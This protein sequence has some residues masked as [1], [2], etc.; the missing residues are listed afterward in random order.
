MGSNFPISKSGTAFGSFIVSTTLEKPDA[1][2][3]K[4]IRS[5][6]MRGKNRRRPTR[7]NA[8]GNKPSPEKDMGMPLGPSSRSDFSQDSELVIMPMQKVMSDSF[9]LGFGNALKP[10]M[11]EL[12]YRAFTI[13]KPATYTVQTLVEGGPHDELFCLGG[14]TQSPAMM[15]TVVFIAQAYHE[16]SCGAPLGRITQFHLSKTLNYLQHSL[17][18]SIDATSNAT[19]AIVTS[20]AMAAILLGELETAT[21]HMDG[22]ARMVELRGGFENLGNGRII[23]HKSRSIDLL[24]AISLGSK[25][26]FGEN[27]NWAQLATRDISAADFPE[28]SGVCPPPPSTLLGVWAILQEFSIAANRAIA[29]GTKIPASLFVKIST[30]VTYQL[31]QLQFD[32]ASPLELLRLSMLAYIKSI[33]M[34]T[35]VISVKMTFLEGQLK[36][37]LLLALNS[38]I[39]EQLRLILWSLFISAISIFEGRDC[40]W[41]REGIAQTL[42]IIGLETWPLARDTLKT[43]P[44]TDILHSVEGER[45]F[46]Q[47]K[48]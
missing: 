45:L 31:F 17:Y 23:E 25:L 16:L 43:F 3:R 5:Y 22:L 32:P 46:N 11:R 36:S 30:S 8:R 37:A 19:L 20:L 38:P 21:K 35:K 26:R 47:I 2:T 41:I 24:L 40:D 29:S 10:Y 1:T 39:T 28:L 7:K 27:R 34:R 13:V 18:D 15:H 42:D 33:L 48:G 4:F 9:Y 12:I 14:L 6:V 44:W